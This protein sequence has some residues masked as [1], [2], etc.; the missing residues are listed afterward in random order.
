MPK[1]V[2]VVVTY[3]ICAD[4]IN[5]AEAVVKMMCSLGYAGIKSRN[6]G[7][8]ETVAKRDI[9]CAHTLPRR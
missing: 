9:Y 1:H 6:V 7:H 8:T 5:H 4:S 3:Y 2:K